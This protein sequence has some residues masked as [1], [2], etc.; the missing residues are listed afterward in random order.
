LLAIYV[1]GNSI[2][3]KLSMLSNGC[4]LCGGAS[5]IK[6]GWQDFDVFAGYKWWLKPRV[7]GCFHVNQ[8]SVDEKTLLSRKNY[9]GSLTRKR[10]L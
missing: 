9:D 6:F 8:Q 3:A 5:T 2:L 7:L 4:E 10:W 1:F